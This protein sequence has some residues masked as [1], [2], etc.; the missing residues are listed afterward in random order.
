[1]EMAALARMGENFFRLDIFIA[2][3][4]LVM[5]GGRRFARGMVVVVVVVVASDF[6]CSCIFFM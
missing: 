2:S 4:F 3:G 1:M 6:F 5:S